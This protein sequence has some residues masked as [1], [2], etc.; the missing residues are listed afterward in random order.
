MDHILKDRQRISDQLQKSYVTEEKRPQFLI[1]GDNGSGIT[2]LTS[3]LISIEKSQDLTILNIFVDNEID[4][5]NYKAPLQIDSIVLKG[6]SVEKLELIKSSIG[7][8]LSKETDEK[9]ASVFRG[10]FGYEA[11]DKFFITAEIIKE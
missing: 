11:S 4:E 7:G 8:K 6:F 9:I 1:I 3:I 5:S 10:G 2:A